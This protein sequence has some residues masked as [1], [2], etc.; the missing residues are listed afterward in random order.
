MSDARQHQ[1]VVGLDGSANSAAAVAWALDYLDRSGGGELRV[2]MT[3]NYAPTLSVGY[4]VG[5]SVPPAEAME[6][7]T[8]AALEELLADLT[9][10]ASVTVKKVV[11]EGSAAR[12]LI[13]EG[14]SAD[15]IVLG[16]RGHGGFL[17]LLLGSVATQV[18]NH[19]PCPV[20]VVPSASK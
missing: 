12:V 6:E 16:K 13:N 17:G 10:P 7:A 2:V 8:E 9:V 1:V 19:A 15:M 18:V 14:E 5:G 20:V 3:W 4:A 11:H